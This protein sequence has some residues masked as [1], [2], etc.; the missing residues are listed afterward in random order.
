MKLVLELSDCLDELNSIDRVFH[1]QTDALMALS[2]NLYEI[3]FSPTDE[4]LKK[5]HELVDR[6]IA[7]YRKQVKQMVAD[8]WRTKDNVRHSHSTSPPP[9]LTGDEGEL[10]GEQLLELLD[11][12]QKEET[13]REAQYS[14]QQAKAARR[15]A[16]ETAA[17]SQILFLFTIVTIIFVRLP[18]RT[19][20]QLLSHTS[21]IL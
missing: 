14:N 17:Q 18:E 11:L 4:P 9:C 10:T 3:G 16:D 5:I 20:S 15:Q 7:G 19:R 21:T 13:L 12:Q 1:S 8:A 2:D 6:D